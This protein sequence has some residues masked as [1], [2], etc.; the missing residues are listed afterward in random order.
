MVIVYEKMYIVMK[1]V[2]LQMSIIKTSLK[3]ALL[4]NRLHSDLASF[5]P[6]DH[7]VVIN[8]H[9]PAANISE[10]IMNP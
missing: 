6:L 2:S 8:T 9:D 1:C 3:Q 7:L 4:K 10:K 5:R